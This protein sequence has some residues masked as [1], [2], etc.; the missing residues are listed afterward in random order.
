MVKMARKVFCDY[1]TQET[2]NSSGICKSFLNP[3]TWKCALLILSQSSC[4]LAVAAVLFL[5]SN[6]VCSDRLLWAQTFFLLFDTAF[7]RWLQSR[8]RLTWMR[9][10]AQDCLSCSASTSLLSFPVYRHVVS[11][12][13]Q[14]CAEW[15]LC[16]IDYCLV[17]MGHPVSSM[18][19]GND[20]IKSVPTCWSA[21]SLVMEGLG[22]H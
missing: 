20:F 4:R 11:V 16:R 13:S 7:C 14:Q 17:N 2:S 6:Y 9:F 18:R 15:E 19:E 10:S 8:S 22:I 12:F 1:F 3:V 21:V 5:S